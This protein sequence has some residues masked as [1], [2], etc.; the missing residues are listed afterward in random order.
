MYS[1]PSSFPGPALRYAFLLV[2]LTILGHGTTHAQQARTITFE[3][4]VQI[5]LERNAAIRRSRNNVGLQATVVSSERA[6]FFPNLNLSSSTSRTYGLTFD[7]TTGQLVSESTDAFNASASSS[8]NLFNGF[9]DVASYNQA[10]HAL[11]A[12]EYTLNRTQQTVLFDLITSYLQVILDREQIQ[13]RQEDLEAQR[14]QLARIEEFVR[15]G[16]R[17]V[18][19]LYQQQAT[20]ASSELA[21][22]EAER[23]AQLSESRLIQVLQL[24]PFQEYEFVAPSAEEIPLLPRE[25]DAESLLRTAFANRPDLQ[26]QEASIE[27]AL[28]GIRFARSGMYPSLSLFGSIRTSYSSRN[29]LTSFADQLSDNRAQSFGISL[30]IPIFNR[31]QTRTNVER[32]RVQYE[33][34]RLAEETLEL[35]IAAE[36]RQAYLDYQTAVKRLDV[37]EKQL[38]AAEQALAVEQER[39][40]VGAST[41]VELTQARATYVQAA[42]NRIQAIYRFYFQDRLLEYYQGTLNPTRPLF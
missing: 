12:E 15:V 3:E 4:A 9:G 20:V 33:N 42:S 31:F 29:E 22:L 24:D 36:V 28:E 11:E 2:L 5:A 17:P 30:S 32:A 16:S 10:R 26:A 21:L 25:Y 7:Q 23:A 38:Q 40:N 19:D 37:T 18:S 35:Q 8:I 34:A 27:A 14:Q 13:I 1:T 41:L 6:D 39:Y